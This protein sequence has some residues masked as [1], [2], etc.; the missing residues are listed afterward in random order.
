MPILLVPKP[1][2][3]YYPNI[4]KRIEHEPEEYTA[5]LDHTNGTYIGTLT[6]VYREVKIYTAPQFPHMRAAIK[7]EFE[8]YRKEHPP[9][10]DVGYCYED[11]PVSTRKGYNEH[12]SYGVCRW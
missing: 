10:Y 6:K 9:S 3:K 7:A 1:N 2:I 8:R 11:D 12:R 5:W 4:D